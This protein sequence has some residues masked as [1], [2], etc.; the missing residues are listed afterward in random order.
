MASH[1]DAVPIPPP[2]TP[3]P[4]SVQGLARLQALLWKEEVVSKRE[5]NALAKIEHEMGRVA[6]QT[7]VIAQLRDIVTR[8][9][10]LS[11]P[12]ERR[13][14]SGSG[15]GSRPF[16][17][18]E[19]QQYRRLVAYVQCEP[20]TLARAVAHVQSVLSADEMAELANAVVCHFFVR[21]DRASHP[22]SSA[23]LRFM[24][25]LH[26]AVARTA[27]SVRELLSPDR[28]IRF[29]WAAYFRR[30]ARP[31]LAQALRETIV[32]IAEM[33]LSHAA[34]I[35]ATPSG[36]AP[37][38]GRGGASSAAAMDRSL[39][40]P[41]A[42]A[43]GKGGVGGL[44]TPSGVGV[45]GGGGGGGSA[46]LQRQ[47][48]T[49]AA[50]ARVRDTP[51]APYGYAPMTLDA[52]LAFSQRIISRVVESAD[53]IPK[54]MRW[55]ARSAW[56]HAR[57]RFGGGSGPPPQDV[58]AAAAAYEQM[59]VLL[60][61]SLLSEALVFPELSDSMEPLEVNPSTR[62][63]LR[64]I[65]HVVGAIF[66][67]DDI[68]EL[69]ASSLDASV[70][71]IEEVE[72][73]R[74]KLSKM[75]SM[76]TRTAFV[77]S[78]VT[79]DEP[80]LSNASLVSSGE[81]EWPLVVCP[82][83]LL[84]LHRI[85]WQYVDQCGDDLQE[86]AALLEPMQSRPPF[87]PER[88]RLFAILPRFKSHAVEAA[89][90]VTKQRVSDA[91]QRSRTKVKLRAAVKMM[92]RTALLQSACPEVAELLVQQRHEL[93]NSTGGRLV[94]NALYE[95]MASLA[96]LPSAD[97]A[98]DFLP[99]IEEMCAESELVI[100]Q[101]AE[102]GL[103][104]A[105]GATGGELPAAAAAATTAA[106]MGEAYVFHLVQEAAALEHQKQRLVEQQVQLLVRAV[107]T[108]AARE[109]QVAVR[110]WR[111]Q[112]CP[113]CAGEPQPDFDQFLCAACCAHMQGAA[114][115]IQ[116]FH[117]RYDD[118]LRGL[119]E[120]VT[121]RV[122]DWSIPRAYETLFPMCAEN[123]QFAQHM[124]SL[125]F[126]TPD[127]ETFYRYLMEDHGGGE[128][129]SVVVHEE[130]LL[131][132]M[133]ELLRINVH[134]G[135]NRKLECIYQFWR[136]IWELLNL[137]G[138][139]AA[140]EYVP[141]LSYI[142][143][144][145]SPRHLLSNLQYVY[146]FAAGRKDPK[147]ERALLDFG[148]AVKCLQCLRP[149][150]MTPGS[151]LT[152][153]QERLRDA[154]LNMQFAP[155]DILLALRQVE[156][157]HMSQAGGGATDEIAFKRAK[158]SMLEWLMAAAELKEFFDTRGLDLQSDLCFEALI[159]TKLDIRASRIYIQSYTIPALADS[160]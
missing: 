95:V 70:G 10:V 16:G 35:P 81:L 46:A 11:E 141:L 49:P 47:R 97:Q 152:P 34:T 83:D 36:A 23:L 85:M 122:A 140:D 94:A 113:D 88:N 9:L 38:A 118:E 130:S 18:Q 136:G 144:K 61:S 5:R 138:T 27:A 28:V 1:N 7:I 82:N 124:Q 79:V 14:I 98:E 150:R 40:T 115:Q 13:K 39:S 17:F 87:E 30:V 133:E 19:E 68:D 160:L 129:P 60:F 105:L 86:L 121:L 37:A 107:I 48:S 26:A 120:A 153:T 78:L 142:T 84:A 149:A 114:T 41:T 117:A 131:L 158:L 135:P 125:Q 80:D 62:A 3:Q 74:S 54:E 89:E 126:I 33:P 56:D 134:R 57:A 127:Y 58:P 128:L 67:G 156:V 90:E 103:D 4:A 76:Q 145:A 52:L 91:S 104:Q 109:F 132:V 24:D 116:A 93:L 71:K 148:Q 96:E 159:E 99:F 8:A 108:P 45:G 139:P 53:S 119:D 32:A 43:N 77:D 59:C 147:H 69:L 55:V 73:F 137:T 63:K 155:E 72:M 6:S 146:T 101:Y 2:P 111:A 65:E 44:T 154:A 64:Q 15:G 157:Q 143:L 92:P 12:V 106:A 66:A 112:P 151:P 102:H 21:S 22:E 20:A 100:A 75:F 110:S 123:E 25:E 50:A 29:F 51:T 42:R 31:Y